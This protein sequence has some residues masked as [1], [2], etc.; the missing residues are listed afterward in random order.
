MTAIPNLL[1]APKLEVSEGMDTYVRRSP[2]GVGVAICPCVLFLS[3]LLS[4]FLGGDGFWDG[5][6]DGDWSWQRVGG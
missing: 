6:R 3:V 5:L 4:R 2:L 1:M